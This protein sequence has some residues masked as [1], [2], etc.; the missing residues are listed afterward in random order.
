MLRN[1]QR[2]VVLITTLMLVIF[3][4]SLFVLM[5]KD[6]LVNQKRI[7]YRTIENQSI[8]TILGL[9]S[10]YLYYI[11]NNSD[12]SFNQSFFNNLDNSRINKYLNDI[13]PDANIDISLKDN[14]NCLNINSVVSLS[15]NDEEIDYIKNETNV[16]YIYNYLNLN[17]IDPIIISEFLDQVLDWIDTDD[18]PR[19]Y[20]IEDYFYTGPL[21]INKQYTGKRLFF[22]KNELLTLPALSQFDI[23]KLNH[24][25]VH[26]HSTKLLININSLVLDDHMLVQSLYPEFS[27]DEAKLFIKEIDKYV[28]EQLSADGTK[29]EIAPIVAP[30][31]HSTGTA[32]WKDN[33]FIAKGN[34]VTKGDNT[35]IKTYEIDNVLVIGE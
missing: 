20:G 28:R 12:M 9:E 19:S 22:N 27:A 30:A 33:Q 2:G 6:A 24:I 1:R 26:P 35:S 18:E 8:D 7:F 17:N 13:F 10:T 11:K 25:C 4:S 3:M 14:T 31:Y 32:F 5:S 23:N 16:S 29:Y 15:R 21:S 34:Y